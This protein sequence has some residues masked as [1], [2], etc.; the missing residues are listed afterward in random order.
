M[1]V[2]KFVSHTRSRLLENKVP[3]KIFA[4]KRESNNEELQKFILFV[5]YFRATKS[6]VRWRGPVPHMAEMRKLK[7][8][9]KVGF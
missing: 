7:L 5:K 2:W 8:K 6:E 1:W 9:D 3:R 4:L